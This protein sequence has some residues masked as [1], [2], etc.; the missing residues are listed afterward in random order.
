MLR[1]FSH[2][3]GC[4][5][6]IP[7]AALAAL[8]PLAS[9][10][11]KRKNLLVG[12]EHA[13]DGAAYRLDNKTILVASADFFAPAV[14]DPFDFGR[15]AAAN[16][17]S[18]IYA[19]GAA[20]LFALAILCAPRRT[21]AEMTAAI[22]RGGEEIC[23]QADIP[24]AGGH[25]IHGAE[26]L[27]GLAVIGKAAQIKTNAEAKAGEI[28]ILGKPLG[29]GVL[30]A[31]HRSGDLGRRGYAELIKWTTKLNA[32]GA[33]FGKMKSVGA[34]TDVTGFGLAGHLLEICRASGCGATVSFKRLPLMTG[35][36]ALVKRGIKT[37]ASARNWQSYQND[38][39]LELTAKATAQTANKAA[40]RLPDKAAAQ[41]LLTDP[42]T[43][44]GLLVTCAPRAA[45]KILA[46]FREAGF[47]KAAVIGEITANSKSPRLRVCA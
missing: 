29:A 8:L 28:L 20:P 9:G 32:V 19:M 40:A 3:G 35:A 39:S 41:T 21:P 26:P 11:R 34:M 37:A 15:I 13:D 30:G 43:S 23:A 33:R 22:L 12:F 36:M 14:D 10:R 42:Q 16:A 27:Y 2:G 4:G 38:I 5:C 18:D 17:I 44:G 1:A 24:I 25:S 6:K 46:V 31:A 45:A 7:P 47:A